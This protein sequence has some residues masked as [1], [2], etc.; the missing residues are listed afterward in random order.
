MAR[1][2]KKAAVSSLSMHSLMDSGEETAATIPLFSS[3][4]RLRESASKSLCLVGMISEIFSR[5]LGRLHYPFSRW[6][7]GF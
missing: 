2:S 5:E 7:I 4:F 6:R 1:S 3:V